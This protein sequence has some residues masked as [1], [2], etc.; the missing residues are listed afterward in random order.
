MAKYVNIHTRNLALAMYILV[1]DNTQFT[2]SKLCVVVQTTLMCITYGNKNCDVWVF[3]QYIADVKKGVITIWRNN[4]RHGIA[5]GTGQLFMRVMAWGQKPLLCRRVLV[6]RILSEEFKNV[7]SNGVRN[8]SYGHILYKRAS[9]V[10]NN[11]RCILNTS[12][13]T[14]DH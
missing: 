12:P 10:A 8:R 14:P 11:I 2:S 7:V 6:S 3:V 5:D 4:S 1:T 9:E 13:A